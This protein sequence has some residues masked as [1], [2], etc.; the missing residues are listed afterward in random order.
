MVEKALS[1]RLYGLCT[2][3]TFLWTSHCIDV[4]FASIRLLQRNARVGYIWAKLFTLAAGEIGSSIYRRPLFCHL[5]YI[6]CSA[7][8]R[9]NGIL[10]SYKNLSVYYSVLLFADATTCLRR[11]SI[12]LSLFFYCFWMSILI[13]LTL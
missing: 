8:P 6:K 5:N 10:H 9:K 7:L 2:Y 11:S 3:D 4:L 12:E 1:Y 13:Q